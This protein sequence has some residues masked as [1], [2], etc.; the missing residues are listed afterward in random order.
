MDRRHVRFAVA[1][2]SFV[3]WVAFLGTLAATSAEPPRVLPP[4]GSG[5]PP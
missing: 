4:A 3:A 5:T 2:G 1:L